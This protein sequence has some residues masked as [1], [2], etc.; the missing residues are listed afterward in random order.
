MMELTAT[1]KSAAALATS[2]GAIGGGALYLDH[3]HAPREQVIQMQAANRVNTILELVEQAHHEGS[4]EWIC[5]T[6][7]AEFV[8]LCTE[9][10][11]HYWCTNQDAKRALTA[12][13]GC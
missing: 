10:P 1:I 11:N 5:R 2:L 3:L 13:A 6:I 4:A 12:K 9:L 7:E 8:S